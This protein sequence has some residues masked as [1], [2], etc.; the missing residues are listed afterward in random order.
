MLGMF[1]H[2]SSFQG[3]GLERWDISKVVN[4]DY[5]FSYAAVFNSNLS[6]WNTF[7]TSSMVH[8]FQSASLFNC[9][10]SLWDTSR[11]MNMSNMFSWASSCHGIGLDSWNVNNVQDM[12][13]LGLQRAPH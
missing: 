7:S 13:Y 8:M 6:S 2:A 1:S 12:N 5:M 11:F 4:L 9:N 3:I 10:L